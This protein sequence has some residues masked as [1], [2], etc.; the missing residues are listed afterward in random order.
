MPTAIIFQIITKAYKFLP[1]L[2]DLFIYER[3]CYS[4]HVHLN[5]QSNLRKVFWWPKYILSNLR[6]KYFVFLFMY[7]KHHFA[8][9]S[10]IRM[11]KLDFFKRYIYKIFSGIQIWGRACAHC[12]HLMWC[13]N[14]GCLQRPS[15]GLFS[16]KNISP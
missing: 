3:K 6:E 11:T 7:G 9:S 13:Q 8:K 12:W 4:I 5:H 15:Q 16:S 1:F 10:W 2:L 14:K